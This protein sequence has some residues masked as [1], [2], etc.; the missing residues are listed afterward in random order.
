MGKAIAAAVAKDPGQVMICSR[1]QEK[2]DSATEELNR[3]N[4]A[5]IYS[6]RLDLADTAAL[7]KK[8][9]SII[10]RF[11]VPSKILINGGGPSFGRFEGIPLEVWRQAIDQIIMSTVIILNKF[12]PRMSRDASIVFILSDAVRSAGDGKVLPCSLRLALVG[13]MKCLSLEYAEKGI[14]INSVSPGPV[15]TARA[16]SLLE[17]AAK[18]SGVTYEEMTRTFAD[19]LPMKRMGTPEEIAELVYFLFSEKST[20]ITGANFVCDGGLTT[21]P[22]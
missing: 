22:V 3:L 17:N 6:N 1:S 11:G 16:V 5:T 18:E 12:L 14:R 19:E 15:A 2:L 10:E 13:I 21:V 8:L 7:G 20:Y 4:Q 9:D